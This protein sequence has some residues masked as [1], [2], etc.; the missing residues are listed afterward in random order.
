MSRPDNAKY[1]QSHEWAVLE[2]DLLTLGVT[3][4]AVEALGD[5][6]FID[7]PEA[8]NEIAKGDTA[9]EI[10]SVKAVG[11]VYCP[12]DG[13]IEEVNAGLGDDPSGLSG[14]PFGGGW[15]VKVRVTDASGLDGMMDLAAYEKHLETAESE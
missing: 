9:C 7:L 8:G 6:V 2:G 12:V 5:I 11:E 1:S 10:E 14:D 3:D 15:L 4:F 13:T